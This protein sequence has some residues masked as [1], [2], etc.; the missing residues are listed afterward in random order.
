MDESKKKGLLIIGACAIGLIICIVGII[1]LTQESDDS[2]DDDTTRITSKYNNTETEQDSSGVRRTSDLTNSS[3]T[4]TSNINTSNKD[5][6]N[7]SS[8]SDIS[9]SSDQITGSNNTNTSTTTKTT[10]KK[11]EKPD[12]GQS[13]LTS[14]TCT[15][16]ASGKI[17]VNDEGYY[18]YC[19]R[20]TCNGGYFYHSRFAPNASDSSAPDYQCTNGN[21]H[22][23]VETYSDG[24]AKY[25]QGKDCNLDVTD[26][27]TKV[28]KIN[29]KKDHSGKVYNTTTT[30]TN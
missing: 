28:V 23:Y 27:C 1:F 2:V 15:S 22:P 11:T 6:D 10:T 21:E 4:D 5:T 7:T 24:C 20:V 3:N 18:T 26:Y 25:P 9:N 8:T 14:S 16:I 19:Y 17:T 30:K 12:E 29:C 13:G